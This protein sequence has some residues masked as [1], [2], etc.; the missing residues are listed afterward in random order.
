MPFPTDA[1]SGLP[2][3]L[4]GNT[5]LWLAAAV[6]PHQAGRLDEAAALYTRILAVAPAHAN[7][8][9]RLGMVYGAAGHHEPAAR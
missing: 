6:A 1:S 2:D 3:A 4:A 5:G 8:L 7:A 9:H